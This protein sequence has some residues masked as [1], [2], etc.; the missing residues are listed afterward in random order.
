MATIQNAIVRPPLNGRL[1]PFD[2]RRDLAEVADLVEQ[3]FMGT[4]DPDGQRYLR[5]MRST[6]K[7]RVWTRWAGSMVEPHGMPLSGYVWEEDGRVTGNL[8]LIPFSSNGKRLY[9]IANV[10]VH[11][12][13]RR[14]GI[15]RAL[16]SAAIDHASARG[17][18]N[19]WLQVRDDNEAAIR[20]YSSMGFVEQAR[21]TTWQNWGAAGQSDW[22]GVAAEQGYT[23]S[24][25]RK[26]H[27]LKQAAWLERLYPPHL[28]WHFSLDMPAIRPSFLASVMRLFTGS[29]YHHWSIQRNGDL[30]GVVSRQ[31]TAS[32]ADHLWLAVP[33]QFDERAVEVLLKY[34]RQQVN[35]RRPLALD[36]QAGLAGQ[37][38][39]LAGFQ[40]HQT[41]IWMAA[42]ITRGRVSPG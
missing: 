27:W 11:P 24:S 37:A 39:Q 21:R 10:A 3:C 33:D 19:V 31:R 12:E 23:L 13:Y 5:Q 18:K 14:K 17:T 1:R 38:L 7:N 22:R 30:L 42:N 29:F 9:L 25:R 15:A 8:S 4:I 6:A 16:T 28:S 35:L 32:Y 26:E 20:L 40:I 2:M 36:L 41:L 34:S